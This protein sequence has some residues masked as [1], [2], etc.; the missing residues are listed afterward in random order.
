MSEE[1]FILEL[2]KIGIELSQEQIGLFKKYAEFLLDYNTHTNLTAIRNIDDIYLKHFY[3]SLL[4]TKYFDFSGKKI[5]DIGCGAGFPGVPLKIVFPDIEL[6]ALDSNGKKT[7][8]LEELKKELNIDFT[9]INDRAEKYILDSR[10]SFDVVTGRA[11]TAMPILA[12]LSIPFV[13][14]GGYF[15][16]YK[17]NLDET[18]ENGITTIQILGGEIEKIEKATLPK[19]EANRTFVVVKKKCKTE[20]KYPRIFDKI[21]K[22]PLQKK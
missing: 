4:G 7:T 3:D 1:E 14:I 16:A 12:E 15:V 17:G 13:K 20:E 22:K 18:L 19:E 21:I 10:E 9:V 6:V 5:L 2:Q 11:V 8:F